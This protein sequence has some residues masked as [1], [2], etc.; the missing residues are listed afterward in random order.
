MAKEIY[1]SGQTRLRFLRGV[2]KVAD[3][4]RVTLGPCGRNVALYKKENLRDAKWSDGYKPGAGV[5]ILNDGAT[6]ASAVVLTDPVENMG[7][8]LVLSVCE[9]TNELAGDG[10]TTAAVLT[11]AIMNEGARLIAAGCDPLAIRRGASGAAECIQSEL[12]RM[13]KTVTAEADIS[14]AAAIS[15]GDYALGALIGKAIYTVGVEGVVLVDEYGARNIDQLEI[16]EGIILDRG[17]VDERMASD[18]GHGIS[19]LFDPY[20]LITD[21]RIEHTADI[22]DLLIEAA[23]QDRP[24]LIIAEEISPEVIGVIL[25]NKQEGDLVI[26]AVKP[27]LYGEGRIWK[28]E[29]L[30]V[31]TGAAFISSTMGRTLRDVHLA[32]LGSAQRVHI[33]RKETV[34]LGGGGSAEAVEERKQVLRHLISH[35]DYDFNKQRYRERL[36]TFVSGVAKIIPG[37]RTEVEILERKMRAEDAVNAAREA[38]KNGVLPGGG[39]A[40][41]NCLPAVR[42]FRAGLTGEEAYGAD[43]IAHAISRPLYQIAENAGFDGELAV[44]KTLSAPPGTGFNAQTFV[45]EDMLAAGVMDPLTVTEA[46]LIGA[47]SVAMTLLTAEASAMEK[48][49][50]R[51]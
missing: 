8:K 29:D 30:A 17:F 38:M 14:R 27:P 46:A 11:Q 34:I 10:T 6:L 51:D 44:Q 2:N 35:T 13:A 32:D 15:C 1:Q 31:Q 50:G 40:L 37:G 24:L 4:L 42:R 41:T 47:V 26:N 22:L 12:R 9:K 19:E 43:I 36:A 7:A 48:T 33:S 21:Y 28:M 20:I 16:R 39:V 25:Q 3:L 49:A 45:Y 18:A 5:A 23:E